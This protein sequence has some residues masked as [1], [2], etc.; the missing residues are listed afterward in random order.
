MTPNPLIRVAVGVVQDSNG[1]LLITERPRHAHLGGLWEFPGGKLEADE[2]VQQALAR[3]LL[4]EVGI[5]VQTAEPLITVR[6]DYGDRNVELDVWLVTAFT[7]TA[8]PLEG[9][10]MRWVRPQQ[11]G[12]FAFPAANRAIVKAVQLPKHYAIVESDNADTVLAQC[13][14][15]LESGI[16]LLQLRLKQLPPQALAGLWQPLQQLFEHHPITVLINSDLPAAPFQAAGLHLSSRQLALCTQRPAHHAWVAAS[17]HTLAELQHAEALGLDFAVLGPVHPTAS[18][19]NA[20]TLGWDGLQALLDQVNLPVYALGGLQ[21][22][23]TAI[24]R[25][26]GAQGIAGISAFTA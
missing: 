24:A 5:T 19:P 13:Q 6:H 9:Q 22:S 7:G 1:Q 2:S 26:H 10:A 18:H 3:E 20:T 4:E 8:Q 21:P 12:D 25:Q 14:H 23:D 15:L 16:T 11:L 17:C